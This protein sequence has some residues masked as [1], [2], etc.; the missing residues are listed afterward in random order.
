VTP[1]GFGAIV[2]TP[3]RVFHRK[4]FLR[5]ASQQGQCVDS[6]P[7]GV[8]YRCDSYGLEFTRLFW[9]EKMHLAVPV[10]F[11]LT[12]TT[13]NFARSPWLSQ[14]PQTSPKRTGTKFSL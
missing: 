7:R 12:R 8:R 14:R 6:C 9:Q 2:I 10:R 3:T 13:V 1:T 5:T 11:L 4:S